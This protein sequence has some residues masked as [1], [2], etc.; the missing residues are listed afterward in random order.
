MQLGFALAVVGSGRSMLSIGPQPA[1]SQPVTGGHSFAGTVICSLR[2]A[3]VS[4]GAGQVSTLPSRGPK[5]RLVPVA[6]LDELVSGAATV[7]VSLSHRAAQFLDGWCFPC[8]LSG[9]LTFPAVQVGFGGLAG[10]EELPASRSGTAAVTGNRDHAGQVS[11]TAPIFPVW[12]VLAR[13]TVFCAAQAAG[14]RRGVFPAAAGR[15]AVT[16]RGQNMHAVPAAAAVRSAH[17]AS[18]NISRAVIVAPGVGLELF[19]ADAA[20]ADNGLAPVPAV[21]GVVDPLCRLLDDRDLLNPAARLG[22]VAVVADAD[23]GNIQVFDGGRVITAGS[24]RPGL[25]PGGPDPLRPIWPCQPPPR[26]AAPGPAASDERQ[27]Y[28]REQGNQNH[29]GHN[30]ND[31][32]RPVHRIGPPSRICRA[33]PRSEPGIGQPANLARIPTGRMTHLWLTCSRQHGRHPGRRAPGRTERQTSADRQAD[34]PSCAAGTRS[35][36]PSRCPPPGR[37]A[38]RRGS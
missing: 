37:R 25:P 34:R 13:V 22:R 16:A 36:R 30:D 1:W 29:D 24:R 20:G 10:G 38:R 19:A 35:S 5:C 15:V 6:R 33:S 18:G 23:A 7:G 11:V 31:Q 14:G 32:A 28:P 8:G 21:A 4:A 17:Q 9:S 27:G 3:V 2:S 26:V 12:A